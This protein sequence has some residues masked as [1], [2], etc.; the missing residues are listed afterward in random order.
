MPDDPEDRF[1]ENTVGAVPCAATGGIA[2]T[3]PAATRDANNLMI[4]RQL[5]EFLASAYAFAQKVNQTFKFYPSIPGTPSKGFQ[6]LRRPDRRP[7]STQQT[8]RSFQVAGVHSANASSRRN[9]PAITKVTAGLQPRRLEKR[10]N[11]D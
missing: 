3:H 6:K 8:R 1:G 2:I 11:C 9:F 4:L 5:L 10:A 7:T